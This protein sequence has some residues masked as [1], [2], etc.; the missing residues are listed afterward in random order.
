MIDSDA[1]QDAAW[2]E[3]LA[4]L[5]SQGT[6]SL[7]EPYRHRAVVQRPLPAA[8]VARESELDVHRT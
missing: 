3:L 4:A 1:A 8:Y 2:T 5:G 6:A 7:S